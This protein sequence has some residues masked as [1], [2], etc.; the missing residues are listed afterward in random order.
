M[1][2][3]SGKFAVPLAVLPSEVGEF[4]PRPVLP[5]AALGLLLL[6]YSM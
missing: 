6:V 5:S 4:L 1:G 3:V 2:T